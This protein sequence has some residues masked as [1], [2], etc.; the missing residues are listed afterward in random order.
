PIIAGILERVR[1]SGSFDDLAPE[2]GLTG[3]IAL[4]NEHLGDRISDSSVIE[5]IEEALRR[6]TGRYERY[7][8]LLIEPSLVANQAH[9]SG[10]YSFARSPTDS[11]LARRLAA[12]W[13]E[14]FPNL[15]YQVET[16]LADILLRTG[17]LA[18]LQRLHRARQSRDLGD[19]QR[20]GTWRAIG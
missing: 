12:E 7:I 15:P 9:V 20:S 14:R 2:V 1:N 16:E 11:G 18:P 3:L 8:R 19:A 6:D 10:L 13:L 17:N 4:Q 5:Y